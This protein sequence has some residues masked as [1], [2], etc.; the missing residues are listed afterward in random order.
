MISTADHGL[1]LLLGR[2]KIMDYREEKSM[3]AKLIG[4]LL[5]MAFPFMIAPQI[6]LAGLLSPETIANLLLLWL[7]LGFLAFAVITPALI[8]DKNERGRETEEGD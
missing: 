5:F 8:A 1:H 6:A 2:L 3:N 7:G 4:L